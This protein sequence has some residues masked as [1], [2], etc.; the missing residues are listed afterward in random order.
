M[1]YRHVQ[2]RE[3]LSPDDYAIVSDKFSLFQETSLPDYSGDLPRALI[4]CNSDYLNYSLSSTP[5]QMT[6]IGEWSGHI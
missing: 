4:S 1:Y 2:L 5:M 3:V 6:W